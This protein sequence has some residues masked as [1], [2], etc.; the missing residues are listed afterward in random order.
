MTSGPGHATPSL[1]RDET[2]TIERFNKAT[3]QALRPE[4]QAALDAIAEKH[5][6]KLQLGNIS[7]TPDGG[8]FTSKIEGKVEAIANEAE[9]ARFREIA[10]MYGYDHE[11]EA[12]TPQGKARLIGYNPR[13]RA[14]PW[15]IQIGEKKFVVDDRYCDFFF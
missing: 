7:Y 2:M 3:L 15:I 4:V 10:A 9:A 13:K 5:G 14:K 1:E 12:D 8:S 11:K 6:I